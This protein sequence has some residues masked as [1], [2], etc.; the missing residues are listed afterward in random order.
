MDSKNEMPIEE[1]DNSVKE[2]MDFWDRDRNNFFQNDLS[3]I[4]DISPYRS[5]IDIGKAVRTLEDKVVYVK[6]GEVLIEVAMERFRL[7]QGALMT[8]PAG[9]IMVIKEFSKNFATQTLAINKPVAHREGLIGFQ[10]FALNLPDDMRLVVENYFAL[11]EKLVRATPIQWDALDALSQSFLRL[12]SKIGVSQPK[13]I[14]TPYGQGAA[15]ASEFLKLV[16]G[17]VLYR[18]VQSCA[19]ELNVSA[20]YLSAA[21][22]RVTHQTP[23]QWL[24]RRLVRE[25]QFQLVEHPRAT[26]EEI[27]RAIDCG[28]ASQLVKFYKRQTGK[29]PTDYRKS[30][31]VK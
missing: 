1:I 18:S 15:L 26:L 3:V 28:S 16:N 4:M 2:K 14:G 6:R 20:T 25:I 23:L 22:K 5:H 7:S 10:P 30:M 11:F 24:N 31:K 13:S 19:D 27:A 9:S 21:V 8:V 29:T 12:I 17:K